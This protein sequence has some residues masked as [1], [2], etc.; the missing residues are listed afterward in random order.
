MPPSLSTRGHHQW[1]ERGPPPGHG[2]ASR[3]R[4]SGQGG[5]GARTRPTN[6]TA[7]AAVAGSRLDGLSTEG[8][9]AEEGLQGLVAG[10]GL[11]G[12]VAQG[13]V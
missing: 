12:G 3:T 5:G 9:V 1:T 4:G 13:R 11:E 7:V 6:P 2:L 8:R 10:R